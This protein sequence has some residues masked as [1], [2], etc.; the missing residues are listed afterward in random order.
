M[1]QGKILYLTYDGLTDPLGQ[2]QVLPYIEGLTKIGYR[3]TI[4]SFEKPWHQKKKEGINERLSNQGIKWRPLSYTKKPPVVSTIYDISRMRRLAFRLHKRDSF[5]LIHCRSYIPA[6]IGCAFT[7]RKM[8]PFLFDMRGFWAD[9]RVEGGLW[10]LRNPIFKLVYNFF[11]NKEKEFLLHAAGIISLTYAA[12]HE[13]QSWI[14][15]ADIKTKAYVIPCCVDTMLFNPAGIDQER[16]NYLK[17][18]LNI[19]QEYVL[20]YLGSLGTWYDI[21]GML[22]YF[23]KITKTRAA[24][25]LILTNSNK[26]LVYRELSNHDILEKDIIVLAADRNEV[27]KYLSIADEGI[28]LYKEGFSR[29]ACS[30]TK[31]GEMMAM[32][33]KVTGNDI[34][35]SKMIFSKY[36]VGQLISDGLVSIYG[37]TNPDD[38]RKGAMNYFSLDKGVE[39]YEKAYGSILERTKE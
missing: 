39:S 13:M 21:R 25:F 11:K 26:E 9:E 38:I 6:L 37:I 33:I 2:S 27:P 14:I 8:T 17:G 36:K 28:F 31:L 1:N 5:D 32:G 3:F 15:P 30:P 35:D 10:N 18:E 19:K 7:K 20:V 16:R 23:E 12:L 4:I 22:D 24:K 34:G 29:K